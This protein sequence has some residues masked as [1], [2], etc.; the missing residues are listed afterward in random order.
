M[1]S[2]P[3]VTVRREQR[4]CL[5]RTRRVASRDRET[6]AEAEAET[7][8]EAADLAGADLE[9]RKRADAAPLFSGAPRTFREGGLITKE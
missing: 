8:T 2:R 3:K 7:E 6:E 5:Y 4:D 1:I 9:R